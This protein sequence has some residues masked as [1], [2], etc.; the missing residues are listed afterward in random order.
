MDAVAGD[1]GG[2]Q[3]GHGGLGHA[4]WPADVGLVPVQ[5]GDQGLQVPGGK[6]IGAQLVPLLVVS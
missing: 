4:G 6:R 3:G 5:A 1:P 2:A